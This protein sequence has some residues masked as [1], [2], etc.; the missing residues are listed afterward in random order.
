MGFLT[1]IIAILVTLFS[2]GVVEFV[3]LPGAVIILIIVVTVGIIFDIIGV[4]A[5]AADQAPLNAKAAKKI[6]GAKKALF[7][8]KRAD[9]VAS[10]CCDIVGDICGTVG[11]A[12]TAVIII[13]IVDYGLNVNINI[14]RILTLAFI[15]ALTV[16]GKAYGKRIGIDKANDIIFI[17]GRIIASVELLFDF[18]QKRDSGG[19]KRWLYSKK[20]MTRKISKN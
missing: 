11:G 3:S 18:S 5:T 17:I 2:S 7:L 4:A 14:L 16:G 10:F 19:G 12:L 20:L 1:F 9:E 6:F 8:V 15:A 13:R